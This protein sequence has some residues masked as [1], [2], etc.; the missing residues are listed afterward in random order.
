MTRTVGLLIT[1]VALACGDSTGPPDPPEFFITTDSLSY[2][3]KEI[4][5]P[6]VFFFDLVL[7]FTKPLPDTLHFLSCGPGPFP[8]FEHLSD[9]VFTRSETAPG[10]ALAFIGERALPPGAVTTDTQ[11]P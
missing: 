7:Q 9:G 10:C 8:D 5:L 1:L 2:T 11:Q 4:D 6:G 3:L